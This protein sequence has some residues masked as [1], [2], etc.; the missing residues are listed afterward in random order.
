MSPNAFEHPELERM[1]QL[2]RI[3]IFNG[4]IE[5]NRVH[6]IVLNCS[7]SADVAV[8]DIFEHLINGPVSGIAVST[9][10]RLF[11]LHQIVRAKTYSTKS[12]R[13]DP[14]LGRAGIHDRASTPS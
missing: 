12:T 1:S 8:E 3:P 4:L 6:A 10:S 13:A 11:K 5:M 14:L 9:T 7:V 2:I